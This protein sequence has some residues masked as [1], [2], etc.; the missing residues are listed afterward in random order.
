M[1]NSTP[2]L[3]FRRIQVEFD[4]MMDSGLGC[5]DEDKRAR[6]KGPKELEL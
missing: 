1:L 4:R 5:L 3:P 2:R 6:P